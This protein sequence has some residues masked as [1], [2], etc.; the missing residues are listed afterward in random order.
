MKSEQQ[1][2]NINM[3]AR[4]TKIGQ[5]ALGM[6]LLILPL[7]S[8]AQWQG[9]GTETDPYLIST[10]EDLALIASTAVRPITLENTFF[11]LTNNI[12]LTE[13]LSEG[14]P[15]YNSGAKWKPIA[16]ETGNGFNGVL[17]GK[18]FKV[19]G[20]QMYHDKAQSGNFGFFGSIGEKGIIKNL[21]I[22]VDFNLATSTGC[23]GFVSI[24]RGLILNCSVSG[25]IVNKNGSA[26]GFA[27]QNAGTIA[28]SSVAKGSRIES[29]KSEAAGFI[30]SVAFGAI[31]YS[32][33]HADVH[34]VT[35]GGGFA[36]YARHGSV[37]DCYSTGNVFSNS[38]TEP[39]I[40][41][42]AGLLT[43]MGMYPNTFL[44]RCYSTGSVLW[45]GN[46][47]ADAGF[48]GDMMELDYDWEPA[49]RNNYWDSESSGANASQCNALPLSTEQ[50]KT[51]SSFQGWDFANVWTIDAGING[52][53]PF[54]N[55]AL[56]WEPLVYDGNITPQAVRPQGAGTEEEPYLISNIYELFWISDTTP[57]AASAHKMSAHYRQTADIDAKETEKWFNQKGW[58]PIGPVFNGRYNG[59]GKLIDNLYMNSMASYSGLFSKIGNAG[60]V[61]DINLK[62]TIY[63][64]SYSG[65]IAGESDGIINNCKVSG[66]FIGGSY[67]GGIVG[68]TRRQSVVSNCRAD[69]TI[70]GSDYVGGIVGRGYG[71]YFYNCS[72]SGS[73]TGSNFL[74]GFV[75]SMAGDNWY[76]ADGFYV[77]CYSTSDVYKTIEDS[78]H[79]QYIGGF[80]GSLY[81]RHTSIV[82]CYSTGKVWSHGVLQTDKGFSGY[83]HYGRDMKNVYFDSE[84][85]GA[86][87]SICGAKPQTTE[88]LSN[89]DNMLGFNTLFPWKFD[90]GQNNGLPVLMDEREIR[91]EGKG[92]GS[93]ADP[94]R[95]AEPEDVLWLSFSPHAWKS[96][97][98]QEQDIAIPDAF[99]SDER[100]VS[101]CPIISFDGTY[102]GKDYSIDNYIFNGNYYPMSDFAEAALFGEISKAGKVENLGMTNVNIVA[103]NLAVGGVAGANYG[104]IR[105][106]YATG[107][108]VQSFDASN[109]GRANGT[110]G[111]AGANLGYISKSYADV[112]CEA[113]RTV[114]GFVGYTLEGVVD[115][116]YAKGNVSGVVNVG[117]FVGFMRGNEIISNLAVI[118]NCYATGNVSLKSGNSTTIGIFAGGLCNLSSIINCYS[119]GKHEGSSTRNGFIGYIWC[120]R[121]LTVENS[122]YDKD[123]ALANRV[124]YDKGIPLP[125]VDMKNQLSFQNWDF[126][127]IWGIDAAVNNGYP[128][129]YW[130]YPKQRPTVSTISVSEVSASSATLNGKIVL[131]GLSDIEAH[132]FCW[133]NAG[134]PTISDNI[135]DLGTGS[136]GLF[137][138]E[139]PIADPYQTYYLR[140][141]ASNSYGVAYGQVIV[142]K[143]IEFAHP[144]TQEIVL[145]QG[146]N[147]IS[148]NV[149]P[150]DSSIQALFDGLDIDLIKN[151]ISFWKKNQAEALNSLRTISPSAGYL[152]FMN[153]GGTLSITGKPVA[154]NSI[155]PAD[156]AGWQLIGVPMQGIEAI[157]EQFNTSNCLQIKNFDGFWIPTGTVNSIDNFEPGKAYFLKK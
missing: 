14:H 85:S 41:G 5:I 142:I 98:V 151:S 150:T 46:V 44:A 65:M 155:Q 33:S 12:D 114:G 79:I 132:G 129:F 70:K 110:G 59:N 53:Y 16:Y 104:I 118:S 83:S 38:V 29:L 128:H 56:V 154:Y 100:Q 147:L 134:Q 153:T 102:D 107:N 105:N 75:G 57:D 23:G 127:T 84:Q 28:Q 61:S 22:E 24:N 63:T 106:C 116:C 2:N 13:Y 55:P 6:A 18:G 30:S 122:Y 120:D 39:Q 133:N 49:L 9:A 86:S 135:L 69:V 95:I 131:T 78:N 92:I 8:I 54:H 32:H 25:N 89:P 7:A 140:A 36:S 76:N 71:S 152:V 157:S 119:S 72:S 144:V 15:G 88:Q 146:W 26:G 45:N 11:E 101:A 62:A 52:G 81:G 20:V 66:L 42:F 136:L 87:S 117:A 139:M 50:M 111:L 10:A 31:A 148:I 40:G 115:E 17:N 91:A 130:Q 96:N 112:R 1:K 141:Y 58:K 97:I 137:N 48:F 149:Q 90:A 77:N 93:Q 108:I 94:Y 99:Y 126:E 103:H 37:Y 121:D 138:T 3:K 51:S 156:T 80:V 35:V 64:L 19:S 60:Y 74:G 124:Q 123:T 113:F 73:V 68:N 47:K 43:N 145:N 125:S 143:P 34:C 109:V 82:S 21:H 27:R 67:I 4:I